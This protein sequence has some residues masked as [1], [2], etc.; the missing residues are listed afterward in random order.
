VGRVSH[1][2]YG[3]TSGVIRAVSGGEAVVGGARVG[4][5]VTPRPADEVVLDDDRGFHDAA[6]NVTFQEQAHSDTVGYNGAMV[7]PDRRYRYTCAVALRRRRPDPQ[8]I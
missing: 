2:P 6:G 5:S 7:T 4:R 3:G 8:G 1:A